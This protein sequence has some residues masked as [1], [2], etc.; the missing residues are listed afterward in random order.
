MRADLQ[1]KIR[2][3]EQKIAEV[4]SA[5][6]TCKKRLDTER[7][8]INSV[9][10][11]V[12][13]IVEDAWQK[14]LLPLK[15]RRSTVTREAHCLVQRL[16]TEIDQLKDTIDELDKD[17][18]FQVFPLQGLDESGCGK[19]I[20]T[21]FSFGTLRATTST[22]MKEVQQKLENLSCL[23]DVKLDAAT[24][25][26]SLIVSDDGKKV[27]DSGQ[28]LKVIDD[29]E[30]FDMFG[31]ILG[32]NRFNSGRSY[33]EVEVS[34][35]TGWDLGVARRS[36]NRRGLLTVNT[37]NGYWV[38]V[39]YEGKRYA[40]LTKPPV[41]LPLKANPQKVGV[42]VDYEEGLVSF[43]DVTTRSHIY[44]FTECLFGDD[45]V[46]YFSPHL[47]QNDKN[48]TPLIISAVQKQ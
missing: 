1:G 18:D 46:P 39:H 38:T 28:K 32:L 4:S 33:W 5:A 48:A 29:P 8:E 25:H 22:M 36:A 13:R 27:R 20:D 45:I 7:L 35:K 30:R 11:E 34:N 16:Q 9:F 44:S 40:A 26:Q 17:R 43:Y 21:S 3:R 19:S 41:S 15:K 23:V 47:N 37:D 31:S 10:S 2:S 12:I 6:E 14:A 42:F 24:A